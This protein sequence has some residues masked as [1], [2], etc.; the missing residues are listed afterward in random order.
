M[1]RSYGSEVKSWGGRIVRRYLVAVTLLAA[2]GL[3]ILAAAGFGIAAGFHFVAL[4]YGEN[5]AFAVLGGSFLVIG[6][7]VI[8][9]GLSSMKRRLPV[10]PNPNKHIRDFSRSAALDFLTKTDQLKHR[11]R[12]HSTPL[13]VGTAGLLAI[14]WVAGSALRR[15]LHHR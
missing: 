14:G 9:A 1:L 8:V 4:R 7:I 3:F 10:L 15:I 6:L 5:I 11:V 2:G 13:A 12:H